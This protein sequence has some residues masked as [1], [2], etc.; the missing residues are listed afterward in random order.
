[1]ALR[2]PSGAGGTEEAVRSGG[3]EEVVLEEDEYTL[4]IERIIERDFFPDVPQMQNRLEWLRAVNSGDPVALRNAQLNIAARRAGVP[5][6]LGATPADFATPAAATPYAATPVGLSRPN[7]GLRTPAGVGGVGMG[8]VHGAPSAASE[9]RAPEMSLNSFLS[10]HTSEDNA[11]FAEVL[12]EGNKK[13]REKVS[14]RD[15]S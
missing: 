3:K 4:R 1:M 8:E 2:V 11:S 15:T 14:E 9:D 5:T 12:E 7:T 10:K 6:P 13:R